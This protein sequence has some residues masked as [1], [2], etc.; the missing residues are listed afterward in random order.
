MAFIK[1]S[2]PGR[3]L[4]ALRPWAFCDF[5]NSIR[6][7]NVPAAVTMLDF[8]LDTVISTSSTHLSVLSAFPCSKIL[9]YSIQFSKRSL[10]LCHAQILPSDMVWS[11]TGPERDVPQIMNSCWCSVTKWCPTL[12][13]PVDCSKPGFPVLHHLPEFAQIRDHWVRE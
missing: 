4:K 12:C 6:G 5:K 1:D 2:S 11:V 13:G 7:E 3:F 9:L 10:K 8:N